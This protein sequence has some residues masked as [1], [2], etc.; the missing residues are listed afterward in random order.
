MAW[1][2]GSSLVYCLTSTRVAL[3]YF[4][5][6]LGLDKNYVWT[7]IAEWWT[8]IATRGEYNIKE[9]TSIA[10]NKT[11]QAGVAAALVDKSVLLDKKF[12]VEW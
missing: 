7:I 1:V 11:K 8:I 2:V 12:N 6:G 5:L 3:S 10:E 4:E 9:Y